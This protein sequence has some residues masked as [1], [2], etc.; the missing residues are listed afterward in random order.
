MIGFQSSFS[1]RLSRFTNNKKF[2]CIS[3]L[4]HPSSF[5]CTNHLNHSYHLDIKKYIYKNN[6]IYHCNHCS[7]ITNHSNI[8]VNYHSSNLL[9]YSDEKQTSSFSNLANELNPSSLSTFCKKRGIVFQGSSIY[10]GLEGQF[11]FGPIGNQ[12]KRKIK[13]MWWKDFVERRFDMLGIDSAIIMHPNV[14]KQSGHIENFTDK[15]IRC[16]KCH[17][18]YRLDHLMARLGIDVEGL[19]PEQMREKLI[20]LKSCECQKIS[21]PKTSNPNF[22]ENVQDTHIQTHTWSELLDF[23]L[24]F[25]TNFGPMASTSHEDGKKTPKHYLRPETAQG[26][27]TNFENVVNTTRKKLPFGIAQ[28]GKAFR[29]EIAPRDFLFRSREFEQM[30]IE[31]FCHPNQS[32]QFYK[33]WIEE[34]RNWCIG[35]GLKSSNITLVEHPKE[36]LSHYSIACTD[37]EYN[38]GAFWGELWGIA[39]RTDF[40][41]KSHM[42]F[43]R[44]GKGFYYDDLEGSGEK[45]IPHIVEPSVGVERLFMAFIHSSYREEMVGDGIRTVLQLHPL[46][47]PYQLSISP[48]VKKPELL[49]IAKDLYYT[50]NQDF[51]CDMDLQGKIGAAYRRQD[52]IGTPLCLTVDWDSLNDHSVTIRD[53]DLMTQVRVPIE[54]LEN[55]LHTFF[56]KCRYKVNSETGEQLGWRHPEDDS[57]H[58]HSLSELLKISIQENT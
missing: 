33:K 15:A 34:C 44:K 31:Y 22:L 27:I 49:Q 32:E 39:N 24:L 29:N 54:K 36:D 1:L 11:D 21:D 35:Y 38:Y 48:L 17:S 10:G 28:I 7:P 50:L 56:K 19:T 23:N 16:T 2:F 4:I 43:T 18:L 42:P 58:S 30:E 52:E 20:K 53:R 45:Y 5:S 40:D 26:I 55:V 6:F 9:R 8:Y 3:S 51:H 47:A 37:I 57:D 12:I 46:L 13:E 41:L 14:W 25:E